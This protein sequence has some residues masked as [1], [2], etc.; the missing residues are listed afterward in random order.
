MIMPKKNSLVREVSWNKESEYFRVDKLRTERSQMSQKREAVAVYV[1]L[2]TPHATT[3]DRIKEMI[4][5]GLNGDAK[6]VPQLWNNILSI[7]RKYF[8][9]GNAWILDTKSAPSTDERKLY[10]NDLFGIAL[11]TS[12]DKSSKDDKDNLSELYGNALNTLLKDVFKKDVQSANGTSDIRFE[13]YWK[14]VK[15]AE[16]LDKTF[17]HNARFKMSESFIFGNLQ[18]SNLLRNLLLTLVNISNSTRDKKEMLDNLVSKLK[19]DKF[20]RSQ[21]NKFDIYNVKSYRSTLAGVKYVNNKFSSNDTA[22][23]KKKP[24]PVKSSHTEKKIVVPDNLVQKTSVEKPSAQDE[25]YTKANYLNAMSKIKIINMVK[26][27]GCPL[28]TT[29][30]IKTFGEDTLLAACNL[31]NITKG[32]KVGNFGSNRDLKVYTLAKYIIDS[33][34]SNHASLINDVINCYNH[35]NEK[36]ENIVTSVRDLTGEQIYCRLVDPNYRVKTDEPSLDI[37]SLF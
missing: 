10:L 1:C 14:N 6:D 5:F 16:S 12:L 25:E 26:T 32:R 33:P 34:L 2:M 27:V 3:K 23:E 21:F 30:F 4:K 31:L 35:K 28:Y 9:K 8:T 22:E 13:G 15:G 7:A 29:F 20:L 37:D 11:D 24:E 36:F 19:T 17:N 18:G